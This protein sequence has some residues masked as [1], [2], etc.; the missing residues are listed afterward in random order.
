LSRKSRLKSSAAQHSGAGGV[1]PRARQA[2]WRF[3]VAFVT[4]FLVGIGLLLSPFVQPAVDRLSRTFV[5]AAAGLI[6]LCG[7]KASAV[8][9]ILRDTNSGFGIEMRNGCNAIDVTVLLWSAMLA[10]PAQWSQKIKGVLAGSLLILSVNL[11]RFISLFY[12]GQYS[13]TWFD[14]AHSYLWQSLIVLDTMVVFWIWV[15]RISRPAGAP[16]ASPQT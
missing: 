2:P 12:L 3:A 4:F 13:L 15:R 14:F 16:N 5:S 8:G 9:A 1:T 11:L 10:F 6:I 7:G